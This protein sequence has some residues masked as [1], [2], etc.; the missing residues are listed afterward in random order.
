MAALLLFLGVSVRAE[1]P[2]LDL[3]QL[4]KTSIEKSETVVHLPE[5]V[6]RVPPQCVAV[7]GAKN[8]TIDGSKTTLIFTQ[9]ET[10]GIRF[11]EC[12]GI[13]LKGVTLDYDPLPFTQ[14]TIVAKSPD[15]TTIEVE[16]HEGYP[17][18][19]KR[20]DSS[21][22]HFFDGKTLGWKRGAAQG[23]SRDVQYLTPRRARVV[24]EPSMVE[25]GQAVLLQVGDMVVFSMRR[26]P[27][28]QFFRSR[29]IV[30][31]AVRIFSAPG[32]AIDA[33]NCE[34]E[35]RF[36]RCKVERGPLPAKAKIAR[37]LSTNADAFNYGYSRKGPLLEGCTFSFM[38][39]DGVNLHGPTFQV[40]RTEAP[41]MIWCLRRTSLDH[42]RKFYDNI[43]LPGDPVR[44]LA[45]DNFAIRKVVRVVKLETDLEPPF[46]L[47]RKEVLRVNAFA[48]YPRE[49]YLRITLS[50]GSDVKPGEM[51]DF[52]AANSSGYVI[53]NNTI[54]DVRP[55]G[56]RI[57][58][59]DGVIEN[60]N[61][62]RTM[63]PGISIGGHYAY[64][65]EA[66]WVSN[67]I[68][69]NNT[70]E[71]IGLGEEI[72]TARSSSP[73]AISVWTEIA[74]DA[75]PLTCAASYH[76]NIQ[77]SG[78]KING[79]TVEGIVV[80]GLVQGTISENLISHCNTASPKKPL[81]GGR[82]PR[83][84]AITVMNSSGTT[85]DK[86]I[87]SEP[88]AYPRGPLF[89]APDIQPEVAPAAT[90]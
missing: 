1:V 39:D 8:L 4:L 49:K 60:N 73:A 79:C 52:P 47:T 74:P 75:P 3:G 89:I 12:Q 6:F 23:L 64:Y 51:I 16:M 87:F 66:G 78:N 7:Q 58:A 45:A 2:I 33:R 14:G 38:G 21:R 68:I 11:E 76:R 18:L 77:I 36:L 90:R 44:I 31:E 32:V 56:M 5:G 88:D 55:R 57:M 85:V 59:S 20:Y 10:A 22:I 62:A 25:A 83:G 80:S 35:N 69:R 72:T 34:G 9:Y 15:N 81:D 46:T 30:V 82:V 37:L 65:R 27:A 28:L 54:H 63:Q 41:N 19:D 48:N 86:N 26:G 40:V 50:D 13:T 71:D 42:I 53:R 67:V 29:D 84:Y 61:I 24:L 17:D 43:I 70:L